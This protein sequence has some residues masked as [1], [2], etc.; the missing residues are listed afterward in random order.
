MS[1]DPALQQ[2]IEAATIKRIEKMAD[3]TM[4]ELKKLKQR[5]DVVIKQIEKTAI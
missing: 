3:Q 2:A 4:L 1:P 5:E